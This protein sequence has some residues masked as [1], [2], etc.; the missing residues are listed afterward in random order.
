[1]ERNGVISAANHVGKRDVLISNDAI[2]AV[3]NDHNDPAEKTALVS[4][5]DH[6]FD[7]DRHSPV[8]GADIVQQ[9]ESW[10]VNVT[11]MRA[12]FTQ[13]ASD[14]SAAEGKL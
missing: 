11:T 8:A 3:C 13:I 7:A 14:G 5:K 4:G 12:D 10:S 9:A 1:M 6:F 2:K